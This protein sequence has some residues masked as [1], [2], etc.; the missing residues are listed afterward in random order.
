MHRGCDGDAEDEKTVVLAHG[1]ADD[2]GL[3]QERSLDADEEQ[4]G[5]DGGGDG[6]G[7]GGSGHAGEVGGEEGVE[8]GEGAGEEEA[9]EEVADEVEDE[10]EGVEDEDGGG[11]LV[12][13][14][15]EG[16]DDEDDEGCAELCAVVDADLDAVEVEVVDFGDGDVESFAVAHDEGQGLAE[17]VERGIGRHG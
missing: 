13:F 15:E 7:V 12:G 14:G 11:P 6:G 8:F 1:D 3:Q 10:G 16:E 4:E 9:L 5:E 17:W 2:L